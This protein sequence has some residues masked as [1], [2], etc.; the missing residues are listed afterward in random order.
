VLPAVVSATAAIAVRLVVPRP[1]RRGPVTGRVGWWG[2]VVLA[3]WLTTL[4]LAI[5]LV[6]AYGWLSPLVLGC[7]AAAVV[8]LAAWYVAERRAR[9]PLVD[10]ATLALPAVRATNGATLPG[11][12]PVLRPSGRG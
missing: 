9:H 8:L 12:G 3:C 4:L 7:G 5:S 2:A 10:L 11:C 6:P 1:A